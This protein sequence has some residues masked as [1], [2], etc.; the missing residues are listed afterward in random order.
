MAAKDKVTIHSTWIV[1]GA[2][3]K[4]LLVHGLLLGLR[5]QLAAVREGEN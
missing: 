4:E 3:D 1:I 2:K 5:A